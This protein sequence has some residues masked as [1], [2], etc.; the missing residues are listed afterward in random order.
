MNHNRQDLDKKRVILTCN[1]QRIEIL[2]DI[3]FIEFCPICGERVV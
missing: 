1:A 3:K 2:C